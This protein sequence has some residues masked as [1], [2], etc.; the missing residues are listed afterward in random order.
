MSNEQWVQGMLLCILEESSV[1]NKDYML[2]YFSMLMQDAIELSLGTARKTHA[3]VLQE[4]EKA[5]FTRNEPDLVEKCKNRQ[6]MLQSVKSTTASNTQVCVFTTTTSVKMI[7]IMLVLAS[8]ISIVV[9]TV[10]KKQRRDMSI[11]LTNV[12]I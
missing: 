9:L 11:W 10:T 4:M 8:C 12:C 6:R 7:V 3:V 1:E 2:S 5:K